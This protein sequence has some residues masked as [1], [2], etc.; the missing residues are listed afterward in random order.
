MAGP[1]A[2]LALRFD[3]GGVNVEFSLGPKAWFSNKSKQGAKLRK[4]NPSLEA[5]EVGEVPPGTR[6]RVDLMCEIENKKMRSHICAPEEYQGW[7][8]SKMLTC[9]SGYCGHCSE[10]DDG[11][12]PSQQ[13]AEK[14]KQEQRLADALAATS[15]ERER[16]ETALDRVAS[17]QAE[18]AALKTGVKQERAP[19]AMVEEVVAHLDTD[20]SGSLD[21]DEI[22]ALFSKMS[23][24]PVA[25]IPSDHP[26]VV[27]FS[28]ISTAALVERLWKDASQAK[29]EAFHS[30]LGL[31]WP[32]R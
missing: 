5:A 8:S 23:G 24:V 4:G 14:Q 31:V 22:K 30:A 9:D 15:E 12:L 11:V 21:K 17:L 7:T 27:A 13:A 1:P 18:I 32:P 20:G 25:E 28:D 10:H 6:V 2:K 16:K 3:G 26:E 19:K 29:I